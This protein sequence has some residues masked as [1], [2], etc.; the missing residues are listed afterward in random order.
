MT[1]ITENTRDEV[2]P[3]DI[4]TIRDELYRLAFEMV[5]DPDVMNT[6]EEYG[7]RTNDFIDQHGSP[8]FWHSRF[9]DAAKEMLAHA[10]RKITSFQ[11][12]AKRIRELVVRIDVVLS[13]EEKEEDTMK[14]C[15]TLAVWKRQ[16]DGPCPVGLCL[17]AKETGAQKFSFGL[18][19]EQAKHLRNELKK[20]ISR[21]YREAG[22][23]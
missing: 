3:E 4:D 17:R 5:G 8:F 2:T 20:L 11:E 22:H 7:P 6:T 18:N 14:T 12:A 13:G 19:L 9:K 15:A 10:E 16:G 21:H 23:D 1:D